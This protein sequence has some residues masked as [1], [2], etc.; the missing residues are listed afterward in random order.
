[1]EVRNG[2]RVCGGTVRSCP[3]G[4][5]CR[6]LRPRWPLAA[7]PLAAAARSARGAPAK[8]FSRWPIPVARQPPSAPSVCHAFARNLT[9]MWWS[10][11]VKREI[12]FIYRCRSVRFRLHFLLVVISVYESVVTVEIWITRTNNGLSQ[13]SYFGCW[14]Q[15]GTWFYF[16]I[17]EGPSR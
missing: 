12:H 13:V 6:A 17:I 5:G 15:H 7:A 14:S 16:M 8:H 1:M 11:T 4:A 2:E 10:E 9:A 3:A